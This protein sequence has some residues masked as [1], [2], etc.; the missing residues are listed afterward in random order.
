MGKRQGEPTAQGECLG[1][2][3][4]LKKFITISSRN[5]ESHLNG[6]IIIQDQNF[7]FFPL[8][9][10]NMAVCKVQQYT[11][12][13]ESQQTSTRCLSGSSCLSLLHS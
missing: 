10:I 13:Q 2:H 3:L 12:E 9:E 4:F 6:K 7:S 5:R 8:C 11:T 1:R